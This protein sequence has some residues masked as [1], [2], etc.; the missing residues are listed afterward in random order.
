MRRSA[1]ILMFTIALLFG[2]F[3]QS[4]SSDPGTPRGADEHHPGGAESKSR[5][6]DTE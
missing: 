5:R 6:A 4:A 2:I 3:I 1:L